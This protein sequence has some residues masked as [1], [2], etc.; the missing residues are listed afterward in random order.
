MH[1]GRM[2]DLK[3]IFCV[4]FHVWTLLIS[5]IWSHL[6]S[7]V[8]KTEDKTLFKKLLLFLFPVYKHLPTW[9]YTP[10]VCSAH[11]GEKRRLV[12]LKMELQTVLAAMRV[13]RKNLGSLND[14]SVLSLNL[15]AIFLVPHKFLFWERSH[16]W[17]QEGY[18]DVSLGSKGFILG[19]T[20]AMNRQ[21]TA[22]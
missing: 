17:V 6:C 12:F 9:I 8:R 14:Q 7:W 15:W 3:I 22:W 2:A 5:C 11:R 13:L 16:I 4:S 21:T 10:H 20:D 1:T 18:W 19:V